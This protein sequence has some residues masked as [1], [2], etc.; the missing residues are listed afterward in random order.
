MSEKLLLEIIFFRLMRFLKYCF[1]LNFFM[2]I[3]FY[4][5][6]VFVFAFVYALCCGVREQKGLRAFSYSM[7]VFLNK[8]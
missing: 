1:E 8:N 6:E 5:L 2:N 3:I 4:Y 7:D